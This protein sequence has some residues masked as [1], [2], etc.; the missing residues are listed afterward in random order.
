MIEMP[1]L[2]HLPVP[3]AHGGQCAGMLQRLRDGKLVRE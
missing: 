3:A 2:L 1:L